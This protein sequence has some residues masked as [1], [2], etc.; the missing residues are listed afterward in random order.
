MTSPSI[1]LW[2]QLQSTAHVLLDVR[3]GRSL[4]QVLDDVD[5]TLRPGVQALAFHVMRVQG[6]AQALRRELAR[7]APPPAVD[8]LLCTALALAADSEEAPYEAFTLVDQAVEAAKRDPSLRPSASFIN[9]CLRR[10]LRERDRL[11]AA[12]DADPVARWNHPAWWIKRLKA[13]HP[14]H[15][16]V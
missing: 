2:R 4:T 5:R 6:R 13:D 3:N 7:R 16:C 12:T 8:A 9:A 15:R 10:F 11:M 14:L 1:P